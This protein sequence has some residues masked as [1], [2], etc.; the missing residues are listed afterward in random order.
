MQVE[1]N[2]EV[3]DSYRLIGY[4]NRIMDEE[5]FE[6]DEEDA[7]EIGSGQTITALYEIVPGEEAAGSG[8]TFELKFRY[9]EPNA[10]AS[11][12][13]SLNVTDQGHSFSESSENMRFAASVTGFSMLL[14]ESEYKGNLDLQN[15]VD[16][17][18]NARTFDPH[19]YRNGFIELLHQYN[20][21]K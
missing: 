3:V 1:F 18:G 20:E 16:W 19:N 9:K 2:P 5:D 7:G 11:E 8:K 10:S 21:L 14:I 12:E 13:L 17:A 4:E 15:I 6:D